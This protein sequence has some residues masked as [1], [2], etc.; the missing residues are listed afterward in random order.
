MALK[1]HSSQ[2]YSQ[3]SQLATSYLL[4]RLAFLTR[5]FYHLVTQ[6]VVD[7]PTMY[8]SPGNVFEMKNPQTLLNQNLH[9]NEILCFGVTCFEKHFPV[10]LEFM[11]F[12]AFFERKR[13]RQKGRNGE[14]E[15]GEREGRRDKRRGVHASLLGYLQH[16]SL[17]KALQKR[18][19]ILLVIHSIGLV[20]SIVHIATILHSLV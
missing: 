11:R 12:L 5:S 19:K 15:R 3:R 17:F 8:A 20:M 10:E 4:P 7:R 9:L 14:G 16:I 13:H 2:S 1:N 6:T 18:N